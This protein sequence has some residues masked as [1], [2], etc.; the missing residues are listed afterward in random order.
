VVV[1]V[2]LVVVVLTAIEFSV[3]GSSPHTG[4]DKTNSL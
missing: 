2:V 3:S 1:V 4:T